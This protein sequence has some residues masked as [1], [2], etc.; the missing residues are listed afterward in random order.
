MTSDIVGSVESA[1]QTEPRR[2]KR[3]VVASVSVSI[4]VAIT[5]M[6]IWPHALLPYSPTQ[7]E[8]SLR[9]S[10]PVWLDGGTSAYLLGTDSLGR[11]ILTQMVAGARAS[12]LIVVG[13]AALSLVVGVMAGLV[14][15]HAGGRIDSLIMRLVDIQ[16]AFPVLVIIIAVVAVFGPSV[17][18]LILVLALASWATYARLVRGLV[19]ALKEEEFVDAAWAAGASNLAI[20]F[21]HYLP[22]VATSIVIFTTFELARLLLVESALS[23]LGLGVQPPTPSW[24]RM[25]SEARQYLFEAWWASALP[26]LL[27]V[28]TVLAF[29]LAGDE[30]RDRLDPHRER[31]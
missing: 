5:L 6:A 26:G 27:I 12:L 25:I 23:F 17:R 7:I 14:A 24:G 9:F 22:N 21:R 11:D 1:G 30:L 10:P 4:L 28:L 29:N 19:L 16:L 15:G 8:P 13:A 31:A 3:R 18:N 20:L 2:R